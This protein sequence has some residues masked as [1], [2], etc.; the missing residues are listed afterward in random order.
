MLMPQ[1]LNGF[2]GGAF[3]KGECRVL[4]TV[5]LGRKHL[6][7]SCANRYPTWDEIA[8]ARYHFI[9]NVDMALILPPKVDYVN[10]HP[11]TFHL[12][13]IKDS[14]LPIERGMGMKR[15]HENGK[16]AEE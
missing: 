13:E 15:T 8:D 11:F 3:S 1:I 9:G 2:L 6:S 14:E 5:D 7:I 4:I 10:F 16:E 12:W